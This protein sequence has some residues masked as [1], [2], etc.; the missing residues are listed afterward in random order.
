M[1]QFTRTGHIGRGPSTIPLHGQVA[2]FD[3]DGNDLEVLQAAGKLPPM[4]E[5][6]VRVMTILLAV[7]LTASAAEFPGENG[8]VT[9]A[10]AGLNACSMQHA[11]TL[12]RGRH[13]L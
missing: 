7:I 1:S 13:W 2:R 3:T 5:T 9:V 4:K 12:Q 8:S 11:S 10:M 6:R